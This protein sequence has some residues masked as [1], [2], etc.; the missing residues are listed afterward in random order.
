MR[1]R[2]EEFGDT[3][4]AIVTFTDPAHLD[5]Y[6]AHL[7]VPFPIVTDVDR[8]LYRALGLA[9][10]TR[11]QVWS[12]GTLKMY[13]QLL[14]Q[15]RR[16]RPATDDIRQLGADV[17]VDRDGRIVAIFRPPTPDAR[18]GVDELLAALA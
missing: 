17:V 18:P 13:A 7:D 4:V 3:Q 1:G 11:R 9:R 2:I 6:R 15:G 10:G 16:L 14:R 5:A 8:R 12:F